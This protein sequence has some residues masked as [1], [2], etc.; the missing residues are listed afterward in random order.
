MYHFERGSKPFDV[1]T[2]AVCASLA[3][4]LRESVCGAAQVLMERVQSLAGVVESAADALRLAQA[5]EVS[6]RHADNL[7]VLFHARAIHKDPYLS[8]LTDARAG[9]RSRRSS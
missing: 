5:L 1:E 3:G 2:G 9:V 6:A 8:Q 4:E 7:D